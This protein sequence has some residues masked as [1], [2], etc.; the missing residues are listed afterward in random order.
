METTH[1]LESAFR[2]CLARI[3]KRD[4]VK[5]RGYLKATH[6][7]YRSA[8]GEIGVS[9]QHLSD[10]LNGHRGSRVLINRILALPKHRPV[11]LCSLITAH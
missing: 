4:A 5:A 8:A 9:Y 6:R 1:D 7:T 3:D 11:H 2:R 10:V